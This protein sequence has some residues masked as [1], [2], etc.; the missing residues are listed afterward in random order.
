M[1]V[2]R[3]LIV[4]WGGVLTLSQERAEPTWMAEFGIDLEHFR[5]VMATWAGVRQEDGRI[6]VAEA[7]ADSPVY[8][9]ERGEI[10]PEEFERALVAELTARGSTPR[11]R[12]LVAR[13]LADLE[14][15]DPDMMAML[16][17]GQAAGL[18]LA[19]LSNS[20]GDHYPEDAWQGLF[21]AVVI[22][23]RVGMRKPEERIYRHVADLLDLEPAA[24]VM[25]DDMP[26]NVQAAQDVGMVGVLHE[27][28]RQT[29]RELED[30]FEVRLH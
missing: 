13:L 22:S 3:G 1:P 28:Y 30:V 17:H 4:D 19:L 9:L 5:A 21:D 23:G 27:S 16:R 10:T 6:V 29:L 8:A 11:A 12:G 7:V 24:C 18:R 25:L 26:H 15:L 14:G 20:W 2:P